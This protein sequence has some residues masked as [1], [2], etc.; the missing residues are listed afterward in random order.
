MARKNRNHNHRFDLP[1]L[2]LECMKVLWALGQGTVQEI[3]NGLYPKR[4]LA[5][6]TVLTVMDR[7]ARK[8]V[9][10]REK[11]G[12]AHLYSASISHD[13]V[14]DRAVT[15][16]VDNF[17][18]GSRAELRRYLDGEGASPRPTFKE[19]PPA[20]ARTKDSPSPFAL[21]RMADD[22]IDTTLL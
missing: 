16:L 19:Q 11:R 10:E 2:A 15:R 17:F 9:V 22:S 5:Y 8:G 7:L 12:H 3:R 14:C 4:P 21:G 18:E 13:F 20:T 1:P 6:T